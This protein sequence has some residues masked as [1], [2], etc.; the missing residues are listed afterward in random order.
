MFD[1]ITNM[2]KFKERIFPPKI[3][4]K[5]MIGYVY[6]PTDHS[7]YDYGRVCLEVIVRMEEN[8]QSVLAGI[9]SI[10]DSGCTIWSN[11]KS[12]KKAK[13]FISFIESLNYRCPDRKELGEWCQNNGCFMEYW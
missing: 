11:K 3:G 5:E 1:K 4:L 7:I 10:D 9:S 2:F 6:P 12:E 13:K 8:N